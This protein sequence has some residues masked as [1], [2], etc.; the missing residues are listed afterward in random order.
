MRKRALNKLIRDEKG[1][2]LILVLVLMV[3]GGI[4]LAPMLAYMSTGLKLG[5]EVY[6][7]RMY[8]QY[9][10]DSGVEDALYK[11][12]VDDPSLPPEWEGVWTGDAYTTPFTYSMPSQVNGNNVDVTIQP[13][14][15]LE[16]LEDPPPGM[17]PHADLVVV[18]DTIGTVDDNGLYQISINYDRSIGELFI[19]RIGAWLPGG[20]TYVSGTSNLEDDPG[21]DYYCEP[22]INPHRGGQAIIW[23]FSSPYPKFEDLPGEGDKRIVTFQFT[24][25]GRP[26]SAFSW[27]RSKRSDI[28]LSWDV[29]IKLYKITSQATDVVSGK[30]ITVDAYTAKNEMRELGTA[31]S[32]D[33]RAIGSTLMIDTNPWSNPPRRDVLLAESDATASGI[34]ASAHVEAAYLYW[35]AWLETEGDAIP[36]FP[37]PCSNF[38]NWLA[39][40]K[41]VLYPLPP[42]SPTQ[43]RGQGGSTD[44]ARTLTMNNSLDLSLYVDYDVVMVSW[45][46]SKSGTLEEDDALWFAFSG[47]S[48]L[49]WT[50]PPIE[51]F[52]GNDPPSAFSYLVP[53]EYI[54]DSFKVMFFL[55][56]DQGNE[57]V[58]ID[59]IKVEAIEKVCDDSVIFK[60][61][62]T[63]VYFDSDGDPA[64][65]D[66]E[67]TVDDSQFLQNFTG[68]GVPHGFSY[69][70]YKDVTQLVKFGLETT[71]PSTTNGN[72]TYTVGEV[73]G[74]TGDEWSYAA[75]SL[76]II[77]AS[78]ETKRHQLY[79]YDDFIY[80]DM[81]CNV[82][83]DD[84]GSPGGIISGFLAP[85]E[86]TD[87]DYAAHLTCFVGEGDEY[88]EGDSIM[89]NG[90]SLSNSESPANNVW[91]SASPGLM[92]DGIDIDTFE[93]NYPTI[94][95]GDASAQV[96]LPTETDSWNLVYII[97]SFR[98]SVTSGGTISYLVRS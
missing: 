33:Y 55:D 26:S 38:N 59:D 81:N 67:I 78:P 92:E 61:N 53:T 98:S 22:T 29:D 96:D 16:D 45:E 23:Q 51:A 86:L 24:P 19:M 82:D 88:Y 8:G 21:A 60:V 90:V 47:D 52:H 44:G 30:S 85:E 89:V 20:Y 9:A 42:Q 32:G 65:G 34:P 70:C 56:F 83:F 13:S 69:S 2:A 31:I 66:E 87:E 6:E 36:P 79:L 80:S 75:W 91:N 48:G 10:A 35:S 11:I 14:W 12:R 18:G 95:P 54:T 5:K 73:D 57:Y 3:L 94:S 93:V 62:D 39:G 40:G 7:E 97:L 50:D 15:V 63:Q 25:K 49:T 1:Q 72:G 77:Y 28:Y 76:I 71:T 46:Q 27:V 43:F 4:I 58:Y 17:L 37:D 64:V 68:T 41:W 84:D 74:D